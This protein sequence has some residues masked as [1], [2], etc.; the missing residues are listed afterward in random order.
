VKLEDVADALGILTLKAKEFD[1]AGVPGVDKA[2][3]IGSDDGLLGD[4]SPH[5]AEEPVAGTDLRLALL[6]LVREL[7]GA[8]QDDLFVV[9]E[10]ANRFE[11]RAALAGELVDDGG[12][13]GEHKRRVDT[14][15]S[16]AEVARVCQP[17]HK[18]HKQCERGA[19][20]G[21]NDVAAAPFG[22]NPHH[23]KNKE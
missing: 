7:D 23:G 16:F 8:L 9:S 12:C 1:G 21:D 4:G 13:D 17:E 18:R 11:L 5:V 2:G 20:T 10:T 3:D 22:G 19:N 6:Q 15:E 14:A